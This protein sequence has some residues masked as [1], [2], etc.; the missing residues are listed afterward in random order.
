VEA[1]V[2]D[3]GTARAPIELERIQMARDPMR[4]VEEIANGLCRDLD[5]NLSIRNHERRGEIMAIIDRPL[6]YSNVWERQGWVTAST[7]TT[8]TTPD[9]VV[10][11]PLLD[12]LKKGKLT[13]KKKPSRIKNYSNEPFK[14]LGKLP[15]VKVMMDGAVSIP[16][17]DIMSR[18]N[19]H[20]G[21]K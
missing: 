1:S 11:N 15:L 7:S 14:K 13:K 2:Q 8:Y 19:A 3:G 12:A 10:S 20:I 16:K 4:H 6:Q 17:K 5:R 18:V 9:M 21:V